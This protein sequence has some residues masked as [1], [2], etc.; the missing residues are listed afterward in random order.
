MWNLN[1]APGL[2][3]TQLSYPVPKFMWLSPKGIVIYQLEFKEAEPWEQICIWCNKLWEQFS[4]HL[5][6]EQWWAPVH[7]GHPGSHGK[8]VAY[9][10]FHFL[11]MTTNKPKAFLKKTAVIF[12]G[13]HGFA[14]KP[15]EYGP[16]FIYRGPPELYTASATDILSTMIFVETYSSGGRAACIRAWACSEAF[17]Y[18]DP[19]SKQAALQ[20]MW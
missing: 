13:C 15:K 5:M 18:S 19:S 4:S 7:D 17:S 3:L 1:L 9:S 11:L 10:Q 2:S 16:W 14:P 8:M 20:V 12:R 6:L